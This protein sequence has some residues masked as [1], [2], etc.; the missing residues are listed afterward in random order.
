ME[1]GTGEGH[2]PKQREAVMNTEK[3]I[4]NP[5]SEWLRNASEGAPLLQLTAA[6]AHQSQKQFLQ[7][8]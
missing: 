1:F 7:Q 6:A 3:Q 2:S 4:N 5:F 8:N